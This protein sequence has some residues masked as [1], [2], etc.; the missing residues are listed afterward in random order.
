MLKGRM[1]GKFRRTAYRS[2]PAEITSWS[3]LYSTPLKRKHTIACVCLVTLVCEES[4][5][6][7]KRLLFPQIFSGWWLP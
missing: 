7:L 1:M 3:L 6:F 4:N 5:H 2:S